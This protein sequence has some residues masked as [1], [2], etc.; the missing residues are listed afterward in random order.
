[1]EWF[2]LMWLAPITQGIIIYKMIEI[3][4]DK[5]LITLRGKGN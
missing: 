4:R 2:L 5:P 3:Y 1:M